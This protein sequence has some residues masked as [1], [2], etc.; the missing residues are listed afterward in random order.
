[1]PIRQHT[2]RASQLM[3]SLEATINRL[4]ANALAKGKPI[5]FGTFTPVAPNTVLGRTP[6]PFTGGN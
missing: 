5:P 1:M 4:R 6:T 2:S 3:K